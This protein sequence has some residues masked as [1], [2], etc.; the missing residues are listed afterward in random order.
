[1]ECNFIVSA[2]KLNPLKL[3]ARN[4]PSWSPTL[5]VWPET[6]ELKS[7]D[8]SQPWLPPTTCCS[9]I[10]SLVIKVTTNAK[11]IVFLRP[12]SL[13]LS[14]SLLFWIIFLVMF[15]HCYSSLLFIPAISEHLC[16][17]INNLACDNM[18]FNLL[19]YVCENNIKYS[20]LFLY[21]NM[22][23]HIKNASF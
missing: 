22:L 5:N 2:F 12:I 13:S 8:S 16:P 11:K 1:M 14:W 20:K 19:S 21:N 17:T 15:E 18:L 6:Q 23:E 3:W 4:I 9:A 10:V 7:V